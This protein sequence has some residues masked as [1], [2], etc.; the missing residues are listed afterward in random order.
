VAGRSA[1]PVGQHLLK[2][3][4]A[5]E[6][7]RRARPA[8]AELVL[9]L[10]AGT[11]A[12]TAR[13]AAAGGRVI[14]VERD[15]ALVRRLNGRFADAANVTVVAADLRCVP[16]PNRPF[17][18]VA[19]P[20]FGCTTALLTRLLSDRNVRLTDAYLVLQLGAAVGLV[21][22]HRALSRCWAARWRFDIVRRL[23][24]ACFVPPP[25]VDAAIVAIRPRRTLNAT[26]D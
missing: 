16:L 22:P 12:I 6:L 13:L 9:D 14:A 26:R 15:P 10:G 25:A 7:V 19:N 8:R 5:A 23:P 20:P 4:Y 17:R 11:G 3:R 24:A 1:G 21:H 18:V 2:A